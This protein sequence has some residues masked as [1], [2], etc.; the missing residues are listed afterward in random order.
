MN[1]RLSLIFI[2]IYIYNKIPWSI[3]NGTK[4]AP[5]L[6]TDKKSYLADSPGTEELDIFLNAITWFIDRTVAATNQ[7]RPSK[8]LMPIQMAHISMSKW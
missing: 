8:E 2:F 4:S 6:F 3:Y 7:G 1:N 5:K